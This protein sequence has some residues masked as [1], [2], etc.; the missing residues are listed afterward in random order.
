MTPFLVVLFAAVGL[1]G[2]LMLAMAWWAARAPGGPPPAREPL[3][4][5]GVLVAARNEEARLGRCLDALL[6]QDYPPDHLTIYVADDHST[7]GTAAVVRRYARRGARAEPVLAGEVS[8]K[9]GK[10]ARGREG[11]ERISLSPAPPLSLSPPVRYVAVPEP[12]GHLVGKANAI[13]AA[14]EASDE[15]LLIVTDADCAP[16]PGWVRRHVAYFDD[17]ELGLVC[18]HAEVAHRTTF[19]AVQALDWAFLLATCSVL[20]ETGRPVTAMGNNMALRRAAYEAVGG[21]PAL[22]FSVT[23]DYVLFRTVAERSGFRVRYPFDPGL[24]T[25]TLPLARWRDAYAQRRRWARGGLWAPAWVYGA[26]AV[27]HLAHL[28]PLAALF[29]APWAGIAAVAAKAGADAALLWA[30]LGHGG[31]R[32]LLRAFPLFEAYLF[33][34]MATLPAVIALFPRISWKDRK[35]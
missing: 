17:P 26:Y 7:D 30:A 3:P 4:R 5:V 35:L 20:V 16:P 34:Y 28:L 32:G 33:A 27:A 1:Y 14:V 23:E 19:E 29:V 31:R 10:G 8:V 13:H 11:E 21:Y 18:G 15:D 12:V 9:G 25:T 2:A 22:P 24:R 6:A